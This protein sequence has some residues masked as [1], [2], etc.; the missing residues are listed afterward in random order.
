[1]N[2]SKFRRVL[3]AKE[4]RRLDFRSLIKIAVFVLFG[5]LTISLVKNYRQIEAAQ[6]RIERAKNKVVELKKE[7]ER[8]NQEYLRVQSQEIQEKIMRDKLGLAKSGE[9]VLVLP[10]PEIVRKAAPPPEEYN[11]TLPDP[12]WKNWLKLFL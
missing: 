10:D 6:K 9:I 1:M 2:R 7:N 8:L 11:E 12:T 5:L 4:G 3:S